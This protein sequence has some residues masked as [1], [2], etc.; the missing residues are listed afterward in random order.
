MPQTK[1]S[2]YGAS[3]PAVTDQSGQAP[4]A[5]PK[6][7]NNG[8]S[9]SGQH[10]DRD[11]T[12]T[13]TR[14]VTDG[15]LHEL[16][17]LSEA[18][19]QTLPHIGKRRAKQIHAM[20]EWALLLTTNYEDDRPEIRTPED[21]AKLLM[22]GMS[23]LQQEELRII[24]LD[25][26]YYVKWIDTLYRGSIDGSNVRV[27]ELFAMPV[28]LKCAAIILTHNHPSGNPTPSREY[29]HLTE[30]VRQCGDQPDL[31]LRDHIIFGRQRF[32]SLRQ[33][34]LGF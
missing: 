3:E 20:T 29:V 10:R 31:E 14:D 17:Q 8:C 22:T 7:S 9:C 28:S 12:Q 5:A 13:S 6:S 23:L 4:D 30:L 21:V 15:G 26:R 16:A 33:R 34:G 11:D 19:L 18:V 2:R 25:S 1:N 24:G 32:A 27:A